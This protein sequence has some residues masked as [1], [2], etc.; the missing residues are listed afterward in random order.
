[1]KKISLIMM[2][3]ATLAMT[4]CGLMG[5]AT[6]T[7]AVSS[8]AACGQALIALNNS[9]KAGTLAITNPTDLSNIIVVIGAYN[10]LKANKA[11]ATYKKAFAAGMVTGG[12]G[13]ITT[14]MANNLTNGLLNATGLDGVNTSN[15]QQKAQT[16]GTIIQL[17]GMLNQ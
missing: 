14:T 16:V 15:I 10:G 7:A 3:V 6:N 5:S 12:T 1:M 9:K 13:N 11:D 8:G 17:L 2:F 4:S